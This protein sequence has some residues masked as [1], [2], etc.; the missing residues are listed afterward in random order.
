ML[1]SF[2]TQLLPPFNTLLET[3]EAKQKQNGQREPESVSLDYFS[4]LEM[5]LQEVP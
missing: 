1:F 2:Y 5:L 3:H 4:V